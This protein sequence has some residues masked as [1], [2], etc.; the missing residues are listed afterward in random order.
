MGDGRMCGLNN[1]FTAPGA[2]A[3]QPRTSPRSSSGG[4][5]LK[6]KKGST[7]GMILHFCRLRVK[8][9]NVTSI[10]EWWYFLSHSKLFSTIR[11]YSLSNQDLESRWR[12][13]V[14]KFNVS[15]KIIFDMGCHPWL[16]AVWVQGKY[17][18]TQSLH[19]IVHSKGP[20][21]FRNCEIQ[22]HLLLY[23]QCEGR[24]TDFGVFTGSFC[25]R[26]GV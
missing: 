19:G 18:R 12:K 23:S 9:K 2:E 7:F 24:V 25:I 4:S 11:T 6:K 5:T 13:S 22:I 15:L 16:M 8:I 3:F 20:D 10:F 17:S 26:S 14:A 1:P 21:P